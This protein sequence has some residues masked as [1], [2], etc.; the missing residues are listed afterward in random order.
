MLRTLSDTH[1]IFCLTDDQI[2]EWGNLSEM[3]Q[4]PGFTQ[5]PIGAEIWREGMGIRRQVSEQGEEP[6]W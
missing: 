5:K 3:N 4:Y 6:E 1:H 2:N